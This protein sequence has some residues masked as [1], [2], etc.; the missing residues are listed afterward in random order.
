[1][2]VVVALM[3]GVELAVVLVVDVVTVSHEGVT[4]VLSVLV[5]MA[6][7]EAQVVLPDLAAILDLRREIAPRQLSVEGLREHLH[8]L[9]LRP[10]PLPRDPVILILN[11]SCP[12]TSPLCCGGLSLL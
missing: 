5:D 9:R 8:P 11:Q 4:A 10:H 3:R 1:M 2:H 12:I 6:L 7:L